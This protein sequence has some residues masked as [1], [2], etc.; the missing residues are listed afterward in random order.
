MRAWMFN[1]WI[2]DQHEQAE[3]DKNN[4][5]H[6]AAFTNPEAV[7]KILEKENGKDS[8]IYSSDEAFEKSMEIVK[9]GINPVLNNN[10]VSKTKRRR[11]TVKE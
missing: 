1:S 2:E 9:S 4:T 10:P 8:G 11:R 6:S 3:T 5:L 7:K